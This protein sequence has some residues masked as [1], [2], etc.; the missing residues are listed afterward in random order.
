VWA[1]VPENYADLSLSAF[2]RVGDFFLYC[3]LQKEV[4]ERSEMCEEG[5]KL[6]L[7]GYKTTSNVLWKMSWRFFLAV[8]FPSP[9]L[10][11]SMSSEWT[12][13]KRFHA[14]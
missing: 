10:V 6:G 11:K 7:G 14:R 9:R 8:R 5:E 13:L 4:S 2:L 12:F 3:L 1:S